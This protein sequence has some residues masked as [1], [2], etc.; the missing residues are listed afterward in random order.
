M[1][2]EILGL[3]RTFPKKTAMN[4]NS[5]PKKGRWKR[6]YQKYA[7]SVFNES[8]N[9]NGSNDEVEVQL[10][11]QSKN[12]KTAKAKKQAVYVNKT[13]TRQYDESLTT[14]KCDHS[15]NVSAEGDGCVAC[16]SD[17]NQT[18]GGRRIIDG[19]RSDDRKKRLLGISN[20]EK[21]NIS[22][23]NAQKSGML[24]KDKKMA[25]TSGR[26]EDPDKYCSAGEK[27]EVARPKNFTIPVQEHEEENFDNIEFREEIAKI[28]L[29]KAKQLRERLGKL[30]DKAFFADDTSSNSNKKSAQRILVRENPKRPREVSSK[31]PV[32]KFRNVFENEKLQRPVFDPRFDNRCGEFNNYIY[33]N[34]YSFLD[35]VRQREKKILMREL[36][37]T[38]E[39]G[40]VNRNRLK[41]ALR[42][43]KNQEKTQADMNLRREIIREIRRENNERMNQG[44]PPIF[45]T[46][47]QIRELIWRK[48][49]DELKRGK[50]LE[51]YLRRKTKKQDKQ[52]GINGSVIHQVS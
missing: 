30:F 18:N 29:G 51:K 3:R 23:N 13:S 14:E 50:K 46:R 20:K 34:N 7:R 36:K 1:D 42:K 17:D 32:S 38:A 37:N 12:E 9:G 6:G 11:H 19:N 39:E 16:I 24:M 45:K 40:D 31:I 43:I 41:E 22:L 47:A 4:N 21:S 52:C 49:Y 44:L 15:T 25:F 28:P 2:E 27:V 48:K 8:D 33:Q 35:E 10:K 5:E 26:T